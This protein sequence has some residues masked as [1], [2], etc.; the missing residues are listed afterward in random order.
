MNYSETENVKSGNLFNRFIDI[1]RNFYLAPFLGTDIV[2]T[3]EYRRYQLLVNYSFISLIFFSINIIKW[4]KA[5]VPNLAI[6]MFFTLIFAS[7]ISPISLRVTRSLPV[8]TNI[9]VAAMFWHFSYLGWQTGGILS[10]L[11]VPWMILLPTFAFVFC[12]KKSAI[13]WTLAE[14]VQAVV[15]LIFAK[16]GFDMNRIPMEPA[17]LM[18]NSLLTFISIL[19][20]DFVVI[21]VNLSAA[22]NFIKRIATIAEA[23][24]EA[25]KKAEEA[26]IEAFER[27]EREKETSRKAE[28]ISRQITTLASQLLDVVGQSKKNVDETENNMAATM[29]SVRGIST[30]FDDLSEITLKT[31]GSIRETASSTS[32]IERKMAYA[33]AFLQDFNSSMEAIRKNNK[34]IGR[35][36]EEVDTIA[37]KTNLLALNATIE[38]ARAGEA[39]RGFAVVASEIKDLALKS[40]ESASRI[41][42]T[43]YESA[44]NSEKLVEAMPRFNDAMEAINGAIKEIFVSVQS[45]EVSA[46]TLEN[47]VSVSKQDGVLLSQR[48]EQTLDLMSRLAEALGIVLDNSSRILEEAQNLDRVFKK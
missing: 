2:H 35:I 6:S 24:E 39:G 31:S 21:M 19:I 41:N 43:I 22:D 29:D 27:A 5:G 28:E 30:L 34:D 45:Q 11:A 7:F 12:G 3:E 46:S 48:A 23:Q 42:H 20:A 18:K 26:Q 37:S 14:I 47:K 16:N 25:R 15:M 44:M 38:S 8:G 10:I 36:T 32:E 4:A 1:F 13:F 40:K 17:D 33:D 9:A